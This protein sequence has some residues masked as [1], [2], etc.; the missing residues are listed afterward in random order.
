M[1]QLIKRENL[2]NH[3]QKNKSESRKKIQNGCYLKFHLT[4]KDTAQEK[5]L[6][7]KMSPFK[8]YSFIEN[9]I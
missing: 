9:H 4:E 2:M 3:K 1:L 7:F 6:K 8:F 5:Q